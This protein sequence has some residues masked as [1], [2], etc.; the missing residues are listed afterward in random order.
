MI[1]M[2]RGCRSVDLGFSSVRVESQQKHSSRAVWKTA[3]GSNPARPLSSSGA[4]C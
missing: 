2:Q 4:S 1:L 3:S